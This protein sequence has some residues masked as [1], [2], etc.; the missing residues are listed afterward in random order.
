MQ[1]IS[2]FSSEQ[3]G[4]FHFVSRYVKKE[5]NFFLKQ[6]EQ[7]ATLGKSWK[8]H[9]AEQE[10]GKYASRAATPSTIAHTTEELKKNGA[11]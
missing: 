7:L 6:V 8:Q 4:Q 11:T 9:Q 2:Y 3:C 10:C 1:R 5:A